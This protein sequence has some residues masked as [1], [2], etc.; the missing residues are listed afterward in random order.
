MPGI[1]PMR[2][3]AYQ[4]VAD[5][6]V[7]DTWGGRVRRAR[8]SPAQ[9]TLCDVARRRD[10]SRGRNPTWY[11]LGPRDRSL[12]RSAM[13]AAGHSAG[14]ARSEVGTSEDVTR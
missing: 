14:P 4:A 2:V 7:R 5:A 13:V 6:N 3:T 9:P 12:A 1:P 11:V 10:R 8:S